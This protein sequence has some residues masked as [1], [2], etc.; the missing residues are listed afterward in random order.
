MNEFILTIFVIKLS[1][2]STVNAYL[3]VPATSPTRHQLIAGLGVPLN[4]EHEAITYGM[5]IS[6]L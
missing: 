3:V 2:H 5:Q 1:F 4:L 6:Q